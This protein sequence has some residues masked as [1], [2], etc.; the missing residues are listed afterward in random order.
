MW[1][2]EGVVTPVGVFPPFISQ[3]CRG[4]AET[5]CLIDSTPLQNDA[6]LQYRKTD[7]QAQETIKACV[8]WHSR[9]AR[10]KH[11]FIGLVFHLSLSYESSFGAYRSAR[12]F[13]RIVSWQTRAF[14]ALPSHEEEM[15][16][17][18]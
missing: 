11:N 2:R 12:I 3:P 16:R 1:A 10:Q 18:C 7:D 14:A 6:V 5:T 15:S 13:L 17:S 9:D 4:A 8:Y